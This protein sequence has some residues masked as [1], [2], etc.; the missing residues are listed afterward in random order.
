MELEQ[1]M[2]RL[3]LDVQKR[4]GMFAFA[5]W[6]IVPLMIVM[7]VYLAIAVRD[8]ELRVNRAWPMSPW[9][10]AITVDAWRVTQ[11]QPVY[12]DPVTG[13]AT[14]MYGMLTT[15]LPVPFVRWLGPDVRIARYISFISA[16]ALSLLAAWLLSRGRGALTFV[17]I[18]G[19][20]FLQ[21]YRVGQWET[22]ARPDASSILMSFLALVF[23][24]RAQRSER[25]RS[26]AIWTFAG[27]IAMTIGFFLKQPAL[28][29]AIIPF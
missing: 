21:F 15:Y 16:T 1:R 17:L 28:G 2:T 10:S 9:E 5:S 26:T 6:G 18:G 25:L 20:C 3:G 23:F 27:S 13:H 19:L 8:A 14:H 7:L 4:G 12:T 11:G 24:Y 29:I 22:E